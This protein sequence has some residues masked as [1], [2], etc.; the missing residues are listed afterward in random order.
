MRDL[1]NTTTNTI[2]LLDSALHQ[3]ETIVAAI[4]PEQLS[5]P[6]PCSK[7]DVKSL[8]RHVVAQDMRNF[9]VSA[10]GEIPNWQAPPDDLPDNWAAGFHEQAEILLDTWRGADLDQLVPMP[11]GREAP[12]RGRAD[13]QIAELAVHGWDLVR[14]TGQTI[15]LDPR[16]AEHA[17]AWSRQMLRPEFRGPDKAFGFEVPVPD[18]API[19]DRMVGWFGRDPRWTPRT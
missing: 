4:Q 15:E 18:N 3:T 8:L 7:W 1:V 14:A 6:T 12:L 2:A 19:Q 17:L 9:I 11:G 5:R 13:Q 10:R 16:L